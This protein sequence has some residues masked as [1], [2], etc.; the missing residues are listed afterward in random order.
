MLSHLQTCLLLFQ[1]VNPQELATDWVSG[2]SGSRRQ[3]PAPKDARVE[4]Q[5]VGKE[6]QAPGNQ[7]E[8]TWPWSS[9][10]GSKAVVL[11]L[12][13]PLDAPGELSKYTQA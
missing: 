8:E 13:Y 2:E 9:R 3:V 11:N 7:G 12:G 6:G 10:A 4:G 1:Q 5:A